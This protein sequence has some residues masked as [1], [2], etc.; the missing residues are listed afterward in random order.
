MIHFLLSVVPS[1][2]S[3]EMTFRSE[4]PTSG[5]SVRLLL[6]T[7]RVIICHH[8]DQ[9][10]SNCMRDHSKHISAHQD[11]RTRRNAVK[12]IVTLT[13]L[14]PNEESRVQMSLA[15]SDEH[16]LHALHVYMYICMCIAQAVLTTLER[17][18]ITVKSSSI[19]QRW[20]SDDQTFGR[21]TKPRACA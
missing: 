18:S 17:V 4:G 2:L 13:L 15:A 5:I 9:I 11:R 1:D 7:Q 8:T 3:L 19:H 6:A 12:G 21:A 20:L 16:K 10:I 14:T